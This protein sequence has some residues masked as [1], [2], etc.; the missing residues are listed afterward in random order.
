MSTSG[1]SLNITQ[2]RNIE[3]PKTVGGHATCTIVYIDGKVPSITE[4]NAFD[5]DVKIHVQVGYTAKY[6]Y[7]HRLGAQCKWQL[8]GIWI[9]RQS[10][11]QSRFECLANWVEPH[12]LLITVS[13]HIHV[14]GC[15]HY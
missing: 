10:L 14:Y 5:S 4:N 15:A 12:V 1:K 8:N 9:W 3:L 2:S 7:K 11:H 6:M 13:A